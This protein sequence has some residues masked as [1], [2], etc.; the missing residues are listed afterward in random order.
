MID[1]ILI[2]G[3][4]EWTADGLA[5]K[6]FRRR[7]GSPSTVWTQCRRAGGGREE[8]GTGNLN[9]WAAGNRIDGAVSSL[10]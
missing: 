4:T 1:E 10:F 8:W 5:G 3:V 6:E 7:V 2:I 9:S